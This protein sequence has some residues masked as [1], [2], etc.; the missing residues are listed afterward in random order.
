[1]KTLAHEISCELCEIFKNIFFKEHL[2]VTTSEF[3]EV[4]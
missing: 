1:M 3:Y 2:R 4:S